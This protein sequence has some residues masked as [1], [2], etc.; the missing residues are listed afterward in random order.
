[1]QLFE[2]EEMIDELDFAKGQ[3]EENYIIISS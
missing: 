1:M 3:S 2:S